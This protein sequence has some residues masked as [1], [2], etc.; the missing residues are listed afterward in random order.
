MNVIAIILH[1]PQSWSQRVGWLDSATTSAIKDPCTFFGS[2]SDSCPTKWAKAKSFPFLRPLPYLM[3]HTRIIFCWN[4]LREN[5]MQNNSAE[6]RKLSDHK[7]KSTKN[8]EWKGISDLLRSLLLKEPTPRNNVDY[9]ESIWGSDYSV[10]R[11][12]Y[13]EAI[14]IYI[15]I[16]TGLLP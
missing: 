14:S 9:I 10:D 16:E 11:S 7:K 6:T 13:S 8:D 5:K 15:I 2:L 1:R 4:N 3:M 12:M